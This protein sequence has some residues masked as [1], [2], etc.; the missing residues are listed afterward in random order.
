MFLERDF[1]KGEMPRGRGE[2]DWEELPPV[3]LDPLPKMC[4]D[5]VDVLV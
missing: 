3:C 5:V 4:R 1:S 2:R